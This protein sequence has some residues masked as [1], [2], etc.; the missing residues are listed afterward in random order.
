[1]SNAKSSVK[2]R[3]E[4]KL[5]QTVI[6]ADAAVLIAD[7]PIAVGGEDLG[8][9]PDE[10]LCSSLA[11]CTLMTLR[12]YADRKQWPLDA[13]EVEVAYATD[14]ETKQTVFTRKLELFGPLDTEQYDRLLDIANKCPIHKVLSNPIEIQTELV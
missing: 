13:A 9:S 1:M 6:I 7:E 12:M 14:K 4:K 3:I 8:M 11:A 2:A 10:L 5:Y